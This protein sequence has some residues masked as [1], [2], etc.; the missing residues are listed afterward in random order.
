MTL[1]D[2][3]EDD[4]YV[5]LEKDFTKLGGTLLEIFQYLMYIRAGSSVY[6]SED[7]EMNE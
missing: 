1:K 5:Q 7:T 3:I 4:V 6:D 2:N